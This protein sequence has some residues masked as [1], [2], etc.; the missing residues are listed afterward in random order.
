MF[1]TPCLDDTRTTW[2][3]VHKLCVVFIS[4]QMAVTLCRFYCLGAPYFLLTGMVCWVPEI[5]TLEMWF[6]CQW[7]PLTNHCFC[8][9]IPNS[10]YLWPCDKHTLKVRIWFE[11]KRTVNYVNSLKMSGWNVQ[12]TYHDLF[13][14]GGGL[15][16]WFR[17][18]WSSLLFSFAK[19]YWNISDC[20]RKWGLFK[21]KD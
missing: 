6:H 21:I 12:N 7:I 19:E 5:L 18:T 4:H 16:Y 10:F 20:L 2:N 8:T 11:E 3:K 9:C 17:L 15:P 13:F 14:W 1:N